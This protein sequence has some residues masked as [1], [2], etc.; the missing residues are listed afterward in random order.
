MNKWHLLAVLLIGYLIGYYVPSIGRATV[1]KIIPY[2][3]S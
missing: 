3:G 2:P 1:G